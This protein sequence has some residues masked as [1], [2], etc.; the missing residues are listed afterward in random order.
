MSRRFVNFALK[1]ERCDSTPRNPLRASKK[2]Q[3]THSP[4]PLP[5]AL[6]RGVAAACSPQGVQPCVDSRQRM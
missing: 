1:I 6:L 2:S 3:G 4:V 5:E